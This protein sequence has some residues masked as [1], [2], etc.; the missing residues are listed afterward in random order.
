MEKSDQTRL[1]L[2][3]NQHNDT[4]EFIEV[5]YLQEFQGRILANDCPAETPQG[6]Q[7]SGHSTGRKDSWLR[8]HENFL[9]RDSTRVEPHAICAPREWKTYGEHTTTSG[10]PKNQRSELFE[11][12]GPGTVHQT[13]RP[14]PIS[15]RPAWIKPEPGPKQLKYITEEFRQ[16]IKSKVL[17]PIFV[18]MGEWAAS[19]ISPLLD[20]LTQNLGIVFPLASYL[21]L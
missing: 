10:N 8:Q 21:S 15:Y 7:G 14:V 2:L 18:V 11:P 20:N 4:V 19:R 17:S 1:E 3:K 16:D 13:N 5:R 12:V 9:S 6:K